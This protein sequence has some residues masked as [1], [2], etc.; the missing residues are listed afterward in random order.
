MTKITK[1]NIQTVNREWNAIDFRL[2]KEIWKYKGYYKSLPIRYKNLRDVI[3]V[4]EKEKIKYWLQG[5]TLLG[6]FKKGELIPEDNDEDIG[7]NYSDKKLIQTKVREGLESLGFVMIRD[8]DNII[9]F[10]RND[11]YID[12]CL[13]KVK[14]GKVGYGSKWFPKYHF[15]KL[16]NIELDGF[17]YTIPQDSNILLKTMYGRK[18]KFGKFIRSYNKYLKPSNYYAFYCR[19]LKK[20]VTNIN[21]EILMKINPILKTGGFK[22]GRLKKEEFLNL[23]IEPDES[24]NWYWRKPHL[25]IVTNDGKNRRVRDIIEYFKTDN[26]LDIALNKVIETDTSKPFKD[27]SNL[28]LKFWQTGNNYFLY[29]IKYQF[30]KNVVPYKQANTYIKK[31]IKPLLYTSEYYENLNQMSENEIKNLLKNDPIEIEKKACTSGKHRVFAMIGRLVQNKSYI[32][33]YVT[34]SDKN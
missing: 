33:L 2:N 10:L 6:L 28:D 21:P 31:S 16:D 22:I 18:N 24:P 27:P 7:V 32:K 8:N 13:F 4:L 12:I 19:L 1:N 15:D 26:H 20:T 9:S 30:R 29:C 3:N 14:A 5:K 34:N 23:K 11:R 25:D 17:T